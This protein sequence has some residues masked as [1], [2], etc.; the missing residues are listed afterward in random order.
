MV[1]LK[2]FYHEI[3]I[4]NSLIFYHHNFDSIVLNLVYSCSKTQPYVMTRSFWF[5][6][7]QTYQI[8]SICPYYLLMCKTHLEYNVFQI[9]IITLLC[10]TKNI[11]KPI[12]LLSLNFFPHRLATITC[13]VLLLLHFMFGNQSFFK[14]CSCVGSSCCDGLSWCYCKLN[15]PSHLYLPFF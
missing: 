8:G 5:N 15:Q 14:I 10:R 2:N 7:K 1:N 13:W 9:V 4:Y 6:F 12:I 11:A 3:F